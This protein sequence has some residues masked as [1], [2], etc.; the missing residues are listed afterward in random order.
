MLFYAGPDQV[1]A[2]A[3]G[4]ATVFGL[5]LMLWNKILIL[6]VRILDSTK[7]LFQAKVPSSSKSE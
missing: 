4:V 5:L 1:M 3:S 2:V 6:G 7:R